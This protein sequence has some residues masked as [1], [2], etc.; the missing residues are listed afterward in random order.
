MLYRLIVYWAVCECRFWL[1]LAQVFLGAAWVLNNVPRRLIGF[2]PWEWA[3]FAY[4]WC[5]DRARVWDWLF[6]FD[7]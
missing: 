3:M 2:K 7:E 6:N 5:R 1:Y 4:E